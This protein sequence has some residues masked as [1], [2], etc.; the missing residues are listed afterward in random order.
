M[1]SDMPGI[2]NKVFLAIIFSWRMCLETDK[3]RMVGKGSWNENGF[4]G[5]GAY[6]IWRNIIVESLPYVI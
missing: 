5:F 2:I 1:F 4:S 3:L 6:R